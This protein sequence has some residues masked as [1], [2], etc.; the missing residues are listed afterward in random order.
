MNLR[1]HILD[2]YSPDVFVAAWTDSMGYWLARDRTP[3]PLN[4]PGYHLQS[5][6]VPN[7]Y[8][9]GIETLLQPKGVYFDRYQNRDAQFQQQME[10]LSDFFVTW[11]PHSAPKSVLSM[12]FLRNKV[13]ELKHQYEVQNNFVYDKVIV[14]RFDINHR[15]PVDMNQFHNNLITYVQGGAELDPGDTWGVGPS[16]LMDVWGSQYKGINELVETKT[17][18]LNPHLWQKAWMA[19]R[20]VPWKNVTN[21][22]IDFVR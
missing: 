1:K 9:R 17:M 14:T 11:D 22:G 2:P 3:D 5:P 20:N 15:I 19:H 7:E 13:V 18:S 21:L 12:N 16:K 6:G 8:I 10:S 4:H